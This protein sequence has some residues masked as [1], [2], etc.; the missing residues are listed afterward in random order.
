M[1]IYLYLRERPLGHILFKIVL[2]SM[3]NNLSSIHKFRVSISRYK[4]Q[5][6]MLNSLCLLL[7]KGWGCWV[8]VERVRS[9]VTPH[10]HL[11]CAVINLK[12]MFCLLWS[13]PCPGW[14]SAASSAPVLTFWIRSIG[15]RQIVLR[16]KQMWNILAQ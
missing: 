3:I 8:G 2:V 9:D 5:T 6:Y 15:T 7:M 12:V 14:H 4:D 10:Q 1:V 11:S 13:L 16:N